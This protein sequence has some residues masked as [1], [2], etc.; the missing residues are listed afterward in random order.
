[1]V[2]AGSRRGVLR[3]Y[4]GA[5]PGVGKTYAMLDEGQRRRARGTDVVVAV[6]ETHGRPHTGAVLAGLEVVPR[7]AL[8]HRGSAQTEM[9]VDAVL[10]RRPDV[11]LVD[12]LAHTNVPGSRNAKRWQDV[13]ELLAAGIDVVTTVNVQHL[14]S[15]N[16]VVEQITGIRQRETVPDEVV[17]R[18]DQ[19]ELVD[20]SP[21]ALRRRLSHGNVYPAERIDAALTNYFRVGNLTA[22]REL[23]LLWVADR[24]DAA[25]ATYRADN[26]VTEPWGARE[27]VVVALTGGPEGEVLLRRGARIAKRGV[28]G[29]LLALHVT[30]SDGLTGAAPDALARQRALTEELDGSFHAVVADDVA[31]AVLEFARG[32]N[33]TRIVLGAT[34]RSRLA[35][36]LSQGV[37]EA[38]IRDSGDI[39]VVVV[40]HDQARGRQRTVP[41]RSPLGRRR[42]AAAWVLSLAGLPLLTSLLLVAPV[43][44]FATVLMLYL[45]LTV[46][47]AL[48]GG[49]WPALATAAC[50]AGLAYWAVF[51]PRFQW[52]LDDAQHTVPIVV[53]VAVAGAVAAVVDTS[54]RRTLQAARARA[55]ADTLTVLAG[56]VLRGQDA[57][58]ALLERVREAFALAGVSLL[59]R[60]GDGR[61]QRVDCAGECPPDDPEDADVAVPATDTLVLAGTGRRLGAGDL[62]VVGAVAVQA[63]TVLER[64]RLR[65]EAR[66]GRREKDRADFRAALLN[67]VSHDL[68]TPLAAIKAGITSVRSTDVELTRADRDELLQTVET[69]T[70]RL[71]HLIDDL[72]DMSRLDADAVR[73]SLVPVDVAD[74]VPGALA[75][76]PAGR[77]RVCVPDE[78]PPVRADAGL[79]ER[80]MA[81]VVENAVRHSP[82]GT[83]VSVE[84]SAAAGEV[85]VRVV[86]RGPGVDEAD[87]ERM[88][89]AFQRL[90]DAP[91]GHGVGLGLAVARGLAQAQGGSLEAEDTPGGGLTMV[92]TLPV[93][94][95]SRGDG[96]HR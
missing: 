39:D 81:N 34:R 38:V 3:V 24:V 64:D 86:D 88:F 95:P 14:E 51:P 84:A 10:A 76:V 71:E 29:E 43:D 25:L 11:A 52:R 40:T 36:A 78:L 8:R 68:R 77:V 74:V 13:S 16:D 70:D 90:G 1:M 60:G 33:A 53:L 54:A 75:G 45:A 66:A 48:V 56:S 58:P 37:G 55:A 21:E 31:E 96:P 42:L 41:G 69:A 87:R 20:M 28:G 59:E 62:R 50:S 19:V 4:L 47:V 22:L 92:L 27:R 5:A 73:P 26:D 7:R 83:P 85:V 44:E 12:E 23:A 2:V 15:L 79:L 30:R 9:D 49:M 91:D 80:C 82:P 61:W 89:V 46:A 18:A 65:T 72:L 32:V 6:V 17:R 94:P 63:Q 93:A 67:A 57:V 35:A